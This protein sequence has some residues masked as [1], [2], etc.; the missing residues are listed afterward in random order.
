VSGRH[1]QILL[2]L[3]R[4]INERDFEGSL[5]F[6]DPGV[7]LYPGVLAPDQ[8]TRFDGHEGIVEFLRGA[9]EAW[10]EVNIE[11]DEIVEGPEGRVL[12]VDQ[13]TFYGREGIAVRRELPTVYTFRNGLIVRIDGF[14]DRAQA[15]EAAGLSP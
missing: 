9:T 5:E 11:R 13:W 15:A 8:P 14:L 1:A 2:K 4:A 10:K 6:M 3:N 12:V 7:E